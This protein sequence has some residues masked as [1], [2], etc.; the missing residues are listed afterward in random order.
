MEELER[1]TVRTGLHK[2]DVTTNPAAGI[3]IVSELPDQPYRWGWGTN[4]QQAVLIDVD[5][6]RR[7]DVPLSNFV[8]YEYAFVPH[9]IRVLRSMKD[10]EGLDVMDAQFSLVSQSL[11]EVCG[12]TYDVHTIQITWVF[13]E[14]EDEFETREVWFDITRAFALA[15][16]E[17]DPGRDPARS[18]VPA[19]SPRTPTRPGF[20]LDS[21]TEAGALETATRGTRVPRSIELW[22]FA[23]GVLAIVA[24]LLL[25]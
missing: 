11:Q 12:R 14:Y 4:R 8:S 16:G 7:L 13:R 22:V 9:L 3:E 17:P 24:F 21:G 19:V 1:F 23:L 5:G 10:D 18:P 6:L 25:R 20:M 15:H 2:L